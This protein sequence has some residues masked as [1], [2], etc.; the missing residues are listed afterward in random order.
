MC[1]KFILLVSFVSKSGYFFMSKHHMWLCG[2]TS[3][4]NFCTITILNNIIPDQKE[5]NLHAGN[6]KLNSLKYIFHTYYSILYI[7]FVTFYFFPYTNLSIMR[8]IFQGS[9]I[10]PKSDLNVNCERRFCGFLYTA[11]SAN[12]AFNSVENSQSL[13]IS[14]ALR[15]CP[16]SR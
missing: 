8:P 7:Q 5:I 4:R 1:G 14:I 9:T 3:S 12:S 15:E 10:F 13:R 6:I 11:N 16:K 2:K